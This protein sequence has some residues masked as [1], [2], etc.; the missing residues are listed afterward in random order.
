[1]KKNTNSRQVS[2]RVERIKEEKR[3]KQKRKL[4][5]IFILVFIFLTLLLLACRI[6]ATLLK[7]IT[8]SGNESIQSE[9]LSQKI[10]DTVAGNYLYIIPKK[11]I[12]LIS[13]SKLEKELKKD[14]PKLDTVTIKKHPFSRISLVVSERVPE[15][16][17][18]RTLS[19]GTCFFI[20]KQG[21]L[22]EEAPHFSSPL[23]FILSDQTKN[24]PVVL[25]E[26][27]FGEE[28]LDKVK[29]LKRELDILGISAT[30]YI[31]QTDKEDVLTIAHLS[32]EKDYTN[33][34]RI[35]FKS[36]QSVSN[37]LSNLTSA[38]NSE[39]LK[40]SRKNNFKD[41]D[42]IDLRFDEKV[43]YKLKKI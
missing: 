20:N 22:F 34:P 18:C 43:F 23:Y 10:Y 2:S 42:Y 19:E 30:S 6:P 16:L 17:Y 32:S 27:V 9:I 41:L 12:F 21:I 8:I 15:M 36:T 35:I 7:T 26:S 13:K 31:H 3:K 28:T 29:N 5:V 40:E 38:L 39:K 11:N 33:T 4:S 1:M 14:F 24:T 37:I 25:G